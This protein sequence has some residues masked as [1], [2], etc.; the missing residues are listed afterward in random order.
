MWG[1]DIDL[2]RK[3][4]G[5]KTASNFLSG[6]ESKINSGMI[7]KKE[8]K[9]ILTHKGKFFADKISSDLFIS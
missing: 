8:N 6:V 4:F 9:I 3:E 1:I 2:I 5:E 7:I